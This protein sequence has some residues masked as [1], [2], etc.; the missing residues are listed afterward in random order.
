M[1]FT[2]LFLF[3]CIFSNSIFA[4]I[5]GD[6]TYEFLNLTSSARV[7]ALGN[8]LVN[9]FDN[10]V[11][12][13]HQL[14]SLNHE[15][16][17][18]QLSANFTNYY[19]G[20]SF[21]SL[22]YGL[23]SKKLGNITIGMQYLN[24][25]EFKR[26]DE[27]GNQ[28]GVFGAGE[29]AAYASSALHFDSV[30]HV[31]AALKGVYS[32]L[33]SYVSYGLL[34]D[35]SAS[36][37]LNEG[38]MLASVLIRNLGFQLKTY[39]GS[40]EPMPFE[41]LLGVSSKLE[42]APLRWSI[43]WA[44]LEKWDLSY[45]DSEVNLLSG[46]SVESTFSFRDNLVSHLHLGAEFLFSKNFNIRLGYNFKRRQELALELFKHNVGLSWGFTMKVSKFHFNYSRAALHA[47]GPMHT[48]SITSN[49]GEFKRK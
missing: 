25:G 46:Q 26:T 42:H 10:D 33:D 29:Y 23:P 8:S 11:N 20:I 37:S 5:G 17:N 32:N 21:G 48:F 9:T 27:Y 24:Y 6:N 40:R 7:L 36:Y 13:A 3:L 49:L 47:T 16:M 12:L 1:K 28:M 4:Q 41:L 38:R 31:G 35:L 39:A 43:T 45:E 34:T 30:L 14:P 44:H 15:G 19:A 18:N 22:L 2:S